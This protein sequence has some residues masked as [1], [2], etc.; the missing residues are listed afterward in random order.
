MQ[1]MDADS[2][3]RVDVFRADG[4]II[5]RAI[6]LDVQSGPLRVISV[7]DVVAHEAR[8]LM[9]L[10][11]SV[12]VPAKHADDY[13]RLE[14]LVESSSME[15]AWQDHRK[16]SHPTT[17]R[18]ADVLLKRLIATRRNLLI[19]PDYSKDVTEICRRCVPSPPFQLDMK[20]R[21]DANALHLTMFPD[22]FRTGPARKRNQRY[23]ASNRRIRPSVSTGIPEV[24]ADRQNSTNPSR[25]SG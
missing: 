19:S 23:E 1:L 4:G 22:S 8:L 15:T 11:A 12:P 7:E 16:P 25:S 6:S 17:F 14:E 9:D 24:R 3:L 18:N 5:S 21:T 2:S 10:D 20:R 13:L